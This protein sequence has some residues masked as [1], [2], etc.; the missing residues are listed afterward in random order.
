MY[1]Y[2][3]YKDTMLGPCGRYIAQQKEKPIETTLELADLIEHAVGG[4]QGKSK[5]HPTTRTFMY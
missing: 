3:I 4:E 2:D 5:L 1:S